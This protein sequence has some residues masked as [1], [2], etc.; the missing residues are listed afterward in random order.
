MGGVSVPRDLSARSAAIWTA[1]HPWSD[2]N[3]H[4]QSQGLKEPPPF[5]QQS[6]SQAGAKKQPAHQGRSREDLN[7][8]EHSAGLRG[9]PTRPT[10]FSSVILTQKRQRI[11]WKGTGLV[12]EKQLEKWNN[13]SAS[14]ERTGWNSELRERGVSALQM[15]DVVEMVEREQLL[16]LFT[17]PYQGSSPQ[18]TEGSIFPPNSWCSCG[19][20][21]HRMLWRPKTQ[22]G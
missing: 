20:H 3:S 21:C 14:G 9:V 6:R 15:P 7:G 11:I 16:A 1:S 13:N 12:K 10:P 5:P 2:K 4:T 22:K 18:Q 8:A 17:S 19:T